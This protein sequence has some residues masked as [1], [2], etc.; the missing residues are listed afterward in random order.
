MNSRKRKCD[1]ALKNHS[2]CCFRNRLKRGNSGSGEE[3][4]SI[5][6]VHVKDDDGLD[7]L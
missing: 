1:C 5:V 6:A 2:G 3:S 4:T 7:H